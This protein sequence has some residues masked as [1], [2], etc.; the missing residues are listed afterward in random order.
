MPEAVAYEITKLSFVRS[1]TDPV[2]SFTFPRN[3]E[4][5]L[6]DLGSIL[7]VAAD[8]LSGAAGMG[9]VGTFTCGDG[10]PVVDAYFH[11]QNI[12]PPTRRTRRA[13]TAQLRK[14]FVFCLGEIIDEG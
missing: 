12:N 10:L 3:S 2:P 1:T 4:T 14:E 8:T 7:S 11:C 6:N 9:P 5:V 13:T